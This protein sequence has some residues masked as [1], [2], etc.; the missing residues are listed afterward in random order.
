[1]QKYMV[2]PIQSIQIYLAAVINGFMYDIGRISESDRSNIID[3]NV[4]QKQ[5]KLYHEN[6]APNTTS[7]SGLYFDGKKDKTLH[8]D[9]T[10][11]IE[12]HVTL[13][14]EPDNQY[15]L[16][17]IPANST[18]ESVAASII[19]SLGPDEMATLKVIGCDGTSGNTGIHKGVITRIESH[20]HRKIHWNVYNII[21]LHSLR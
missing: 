8:K 7:L 4:V 21:H 9:V 5:R 18:G 17:T 3:R 6:N 16:H 14:N 12:E 11:R 13:V 20:L 10:K 1:M 15:I 19:E 2:F